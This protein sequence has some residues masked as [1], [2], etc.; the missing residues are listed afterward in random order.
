M[1]APYDHVSRLGQLSEASS[2]E[3]TLLA[4]LAEEVLQNVYNPDGLNIG[5]N[6][7][8]AAGAGIEQH[9]HLHVVPR[10]EGD[11]NFMTS[12]GQTRVM[13]E[14]LEQTYT[15]LKRAFAEY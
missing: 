10:W 1:I 6:L 7:G 5:L 3:I 14:S 13:P 9:L 15:K 8:R 11:A 2:H 4:R 12:V